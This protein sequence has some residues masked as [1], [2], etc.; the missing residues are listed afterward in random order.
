MKLL[1]NFVFTLSTTSAKLSCHPSIAPR[2][3][4]P[5]VV[6]RVTTIGLEA[7]PLHH[8]AGSLGWNKFPQALF[9][10]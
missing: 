4:T 9:G 7:L 5:L 8:S 10:V 1:I 3:S 2:I 6:T